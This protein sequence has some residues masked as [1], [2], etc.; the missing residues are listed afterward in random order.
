MRSKV[1][2]GTR[3]YD[4]GVKRTAQSVRYE[5]ITPIGM[6]RVA[7]AAH[8]GA[9]K[10]GAYNVEQGLPISVFAN[11]ALA[12]IYAY[13]SGDR[14]E[15][16]LGHAAWNMLFACHS[17]ERHPELNTDLRAAGCTAPKP[18]PKTEE[19]PE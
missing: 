11:H 1:A 16:H 6:R 10:Y 2:G 5:L 7:E 4:N 3:I 19:A 8:A 12:H 17:E 18:E 9:E 13:L 14:S 15:D